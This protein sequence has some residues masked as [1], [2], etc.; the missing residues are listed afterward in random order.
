MAKRHNERLMGLFFCMVGIGYAGPAMGADRVDV[1][2]QAGEEVAAPA[3]D[4]TAAPAPAAEATAPVE[5]EVE[6]EAPAAEPAPVEMEVVEAADEGDALPQGQT[7]DVGSFGQIDLHVKDLELTKVL[8]LLSIQSQRNIVATRNVAGTVSA[9]LYG[10]GFY[11]ALD[12]VLHTN[13]FAYEEKGNF[14]Y[15]YT[16]EEMAAREKAKRQA[17]TKIVRLSYMN[18]ADAS[19]FLTPL[20]STDGSIAVSGEVGDGFQPTLSDG[21]ANSFADSDTLVIRDYPENVEEIMTVL[22]ELDVRPK[23]VLVEATVLQARLNEANAFGVDFA[24]FGD[25]DVT[26]F[27]S[28]LGAV[29]DLVAGTGAGDAA[30]DS[31]NAIV[32]NPG[33]VA[34]GQSTIKLGF[35]GNDAA[36]F[37]RALDTVTDTTVLATPKV[38][39][40]NR[41][42]AELLVG[43]KLGYLSTTATETS[44]TQTVEFLDVGTQLTVRPFVSDDGFVRLELQPS[45]SD[46]NTSR[47]VNGFVIP[48]ET[49]QEVT[50]NVIV[51]SGQTVVLGGLFKEDNSIA[52]KQVPG[53]GSVPILG[54][55]FKGQDDTIERS[56]VIFLI[57]PTVMKDQ[58]L[59]AAGERAIDSIQLAQVGAREGLLP[60]SRTKLTTSH[61]KEAYEYLREGNED[62]A[63]WHTN[64]AL[65]LNPGYVEALRLK[66]KLTGE[67]I[68]LQDR[69]MLEDAIDSMIQD[70]LGEPDAPGVPTDQMMDEPATPA[71]EA[72]ADTDAP[73]TVE[74]AEA[75]GELEAA[76]SAA[77]SDAEVDAAVAEF[78]A[79]DAAT[80][81]AA[82]GVSQ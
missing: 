19:T 34:N 29:N 14:I 16:A 71:T 35:L 51:R 9:D 57:K 22:E 50:T 24:L 74:D 77:P 20:L 46:G 2:G 30:L 3:M 36:V 72:P 27:T 10:V 63:L 38:L 52:R 68:Y 37:I 6:V 1:P 25:L 18:A 45:V 59:Y 73:A 23:Q 42:K 47:V 70:E 82:V 32:S 80:E 61:M 54:N 48:E 39:V 65:Y 49:A 64:L 17:V 12:A 40:L 67:R 69:S 76:L 53:L 75:M 8:Q 31:G 28:P 7:V 33:N 11:E 55:A 58:A 15:V 43:E 66:E 81:T 79:A 78:D 4:V 13:G 5:V 26:D 21:G 56:E 41:Q 62:K 60:W 44:T